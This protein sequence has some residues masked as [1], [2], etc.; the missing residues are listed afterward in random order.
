MYRHPHCQI[1]AYTGKIV[2]LETFDGAAYTA[3]A[4]GSA[5]S[6]SDYLMEAKMKDEFQRALESQDT[7]HLAD[8]F[9]KHWGVGGTAD[10]LSKQF[11]LGLKAYFLKR[12]EHELLEFPRWS[13][14]QNAAA[15]SHEM[16]YIEFDIDVTV[17]SEILKATDKPMTDQWCETTHYKVLS[18]YHG[19]CVYK[20][21][22][23]ND[24]IGY[25]KDG[26]NFVELKN[27]VDMDF[28]FADQDGEPVKCPLCGEPL[29]D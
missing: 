3:T 8:F 18:P 12:I 4:Y 22:Q 7:A 27:K 21:R 10:P 29:E 13:D 28:E 19:Y 23:N 15:A 20:W 9:I 17:F 11:S 1:P 5:F 24:A 16:P 2:R 25:V 6:F 14:H 26:F